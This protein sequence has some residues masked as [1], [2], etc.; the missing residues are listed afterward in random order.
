MMEAL[1]RAVAAGVRRAEGMGIRVS[2]AVVDGVGDVLLLYRMPGAYRFSP[3]VALAKARTAALFGRPTGDLA[4]RAAANLPFYLG[5]TVLEGLVFG[6]GG[7][8]LMRGGEAAG[9]VGVSGGTGDQD[10]EVAAAVVAALAD[11]SL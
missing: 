3:A 4:Q 5:L 10:E 1:A 9:G 6:K 11:L 2:I 8:P 7:L